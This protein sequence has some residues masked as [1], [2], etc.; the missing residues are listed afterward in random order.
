MDLKVINL[1]I[2]T[3]K[4]ILIDMEIS[5]IIGA[6]TCSAGVSIG[7]GTTIL[8]VCRDTKQLS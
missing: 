5:S 2:P 7:T 3:A 1:H 8:R 4:V 6:N